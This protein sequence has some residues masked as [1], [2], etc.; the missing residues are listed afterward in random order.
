MK[1]HHRRFRIASRLGGVPGNIRRFAN[2]VLIAL[3]VSTTMPARITIAQETPPVTYTFQECD[4]I[5]EARLRDELNGITQSIF[6]PE[7]IRLEIEATVDRKWAELD[8][9]STVDAAVQQ[10][11]IFWSC[12][13]SS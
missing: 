1:A 5:E 13:Q 9:D 7:K 4:Q 8:L 3:L 11:W 10:S 2:V 12:T 6:E